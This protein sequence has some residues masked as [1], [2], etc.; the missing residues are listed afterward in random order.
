M[1]NP[2][3]HWEITAKDAPKIQKFYADLFDWHID[4]N[5]MGYGFVDTHAEGGIN[6]SIPQEE[7]G[8]KRI[9]IFVEVDDL[10]AYLDKAE[11][12][13]GKTIMPPTV[14]PDTVTLAMFTDPEGNVT[15]LVKSEQH[16]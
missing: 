7:D 11:K 10:Q 14:I 16:N 3:V 15:G 1:P 6:G 2:V 5:P 9:T 13:G 4:S 12:L 8:N